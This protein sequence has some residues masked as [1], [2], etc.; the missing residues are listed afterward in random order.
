MPYS[1]TTMPDFRPTGT[2]CLSSLPVLQ[3]WLI[4]AFGK[5][6][7]GRVEFPELFA[8]YWTGIRTWMRNRNPIQKSD[9]PKWI[10]PAG[11]MGTNSCQLLHGSGKSVNRP[12]YPSAVVSASG[13]G[14]TVENNDVVV[15]RKWAD[16]GSISSFRVKTNI[17]ISVYRINARQPKVECICAGKESNWQ[18]GKSNQELPATDAIEA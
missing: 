9:M 8:G 4:P 6:D 11:N 1:A 5:E 14:G 13:P 7:P 17:I 16:N 15:D 10:S 18:S 12:Y 3:V 2:F